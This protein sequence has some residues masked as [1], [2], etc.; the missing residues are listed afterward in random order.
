[1]HPKKESLAVYYQRRGSAGLEKKN[2]AVDH[3]QKEVFPSKSGVSKFF[4][5]NNEQ[6]SR[7]YCS[8]S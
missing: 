7:D 2:L 1:M 5:G 3:H 8:F 6:F 4:L